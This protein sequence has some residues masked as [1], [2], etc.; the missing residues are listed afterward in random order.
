M[1]VE[2]LRGCFGIIHAVISFQLTLDSNQIAHN[3]QLAYVIVFSL[4]LYCLAVAAGS[5]ES[6]RAGFQ[7]KE[8]SSS[9]SFW[10][11]GALEVARLQIY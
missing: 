5:A 11:A 8:G 6:H 10:S 2:I 1:V 9:C 7:V 4:P 3:N